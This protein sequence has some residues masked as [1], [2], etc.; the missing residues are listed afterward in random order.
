[1]ANNN[2]FYS[3]YSTN[4]AVAQSGYVCSN[5]INE[6]DT[7]FDIS[8]SSQGSIG[9]ITDS[10]GKQLASIPLDQIHAAG[11]TQYNCETKIL[12]PWSCCL[13]QGQEYGLACA[14][15]YY[16]IP[17]KVAAIDNYEYYISCEFDMIYNNFTPYKMHIEAKLDSENS[18][19]DIINKE[20]KKYNIDVAASIQTLP[21][22]CCNCEHDYMVF[23]S[24]KHGYFYYINNLKI[25]LQF[26]N[27]DYPYSPFSHDAS[28][29]KTVIFNSIESNHPLKEGQIYNKNTYEVDCELYK[30]LIYNYQGAINDLD[31]FKEAV[32]LLKTIE[33]H[34]FEEDD[35]IEQ[36]NYLIKYTAYNEPIIDEYAYGDYSQLDII[37]NI[38]EDIQSNIDEYI[39]YF[40]DFYWLIEDKNRRVPLMKYPNGAFRGIVLIPD[41][42]TNT[43]Q[44]DNASLW[45]NHVKSQV[46]LYRPTKE[47][48]FLPRIYGVLSNATIMAEHDNFNK[49]A[50]MKLTGLVSNCECT[51]SIK[52]G[53]QDSLDTNYTDPYRPDHSIYEDT[54]Y[55][56]QNAYACK[57]NVIG[58]F[59]YMQYVNE[60]KLW[61][62]V[63]QSYMIIGNEDNTQMKEKN[64]PTSLIIYNPNPVPIRIKYLIFS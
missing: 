46:K 22:P 52:D 29:L 39:N 30:W 17:H 34:P 54:I 45:V 5:A 19:T 25:T 32:K 10:N 53:W 55:M 56:G 42:P 4:N 12:Q 63:G 44:Y 60:N 38:V 35:I 33:D 48:Q 9:T 6:D 43:D 31:K 1:M 57:R 61:N 62:K 14:S 27:E 58:L 50:D 37:I 26:A 64:L 16:M 18:I 36:V 59:R 15:Y 7:S 47:G 13:L 3:L 49:F 41:W 21:E 51:N 8:S 28:D 20:L 40:N 23:F 2:L 11:I 24:Q